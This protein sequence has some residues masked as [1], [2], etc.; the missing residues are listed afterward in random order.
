MDSFQPRMLSVK[1]HDNN[2][3]QHTLVIK[4]EDSGIRLAEFLDLLL[5]N[6]V[7]VG[8]LLNLSVPPFKNLRCEKIIISTPEVCSKNEVG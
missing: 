8:K 1:V 6:S 3:K 2:E 7:T 4:S 5:T